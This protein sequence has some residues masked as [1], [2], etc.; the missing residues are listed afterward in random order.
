MMKT[1][2]LTRRGTRWNIALYGFK[3][4]GIQPI[5]NLET[6]QKGTILDKE[7][8]IS[9]SYTTFCNSI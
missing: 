8:L 1:T 6:P 3:T 4:N 2:D 7:G 9:L 5:N